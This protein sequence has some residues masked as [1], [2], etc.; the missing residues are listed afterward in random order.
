MLVGKDRRLSCQEVGSGLGSTDSSNSAT[1]SKVGNTS[2]EARAEALKL[3]FAGL[4]AM[5]SL[6][7]MKQLL[8]FSWLLSPT[9][10]EQLKKKEA[11]LW[12]QL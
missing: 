7:Q 12:A 10:Q 5:T 1:R 4:G 2:R 8:V 11:D 3:K 6:D 9:E